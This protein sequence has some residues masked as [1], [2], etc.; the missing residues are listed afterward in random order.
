MLEFGTSPTP[1]CTEHHRPCSWDPGW[2][3]AYATCLCCVLTYIH[4]VV[5]F[6]FQVWPGFMIGHGRR[7]LRDIPRRRLQV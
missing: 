4:D 3:D 7:S 2:E 1:I 6:M 5:L